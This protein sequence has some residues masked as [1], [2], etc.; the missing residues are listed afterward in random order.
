MTKLEKLA[1][2]EGMDEYEMLERGTYDSVAAGICT[3][4]GCEFTIDVEPDQDQGWCDCCEAGT[5]SS[6]LVLAGII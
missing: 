4:K 6:C 1:E 2:L 5:V 3:N